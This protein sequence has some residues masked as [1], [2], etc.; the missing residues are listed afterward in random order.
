MKYFQQ[1]P[2]VLVTNEK[3][4][5]TLYTNI[6][7][8]ASIINSLLND[9]VLFYTYDIQDGDTPEIVADKFYGDSYRYW[10]VLFANQMLD[11]QWDW[12][13]NSSVFNQYIADKYQDIDP[14][15]TV[16][17]Y[18]KIVTQY[19]T[20]TKLTTVE[21]F[22]IDE[23]TYD[24]LTPSETTY[25]FPSS[26]TTITVSKNAKTLFEYEM[27]KNEAK[28]NIKLLKKEYSL[29]IEDELKTLMSA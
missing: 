17:Q 3:G 11:P 1:L 4:V 14:Y 19:D 18:E 15:T 21:N 5:S 28:R 27:E 25:T 12:P 6:M 9:P 20:A 22:V 8:R 24:T 10:L 16:Y 23:N 13:L 2:K 7:A 26:T 29:K